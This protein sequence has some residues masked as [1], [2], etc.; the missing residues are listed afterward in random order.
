MFPQR[1]LSRSAHHRADFHL[2]AGS[3]PEKKQ[4]R[5]MR[6]PELLR[7]L[8]GPD[9]LCARSSPDPTASLC[10]TGGWGSASHLTTKRSP[11]RPGQST[12][13]GAQHRAGLFFFT[14]KNRPQRRRIVAAG[15]CRGSSGGSPRGRRYT[16]RDRRSFL[17]LQALPH[18]KRQPEAPVR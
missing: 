1:P 17:S 8:A 18:Q 15:Y 13:A 9:G 7:M 2:G 12:N 6:T 14:A 11:Q 5:R 4:P 16:L 3:G 10:Q